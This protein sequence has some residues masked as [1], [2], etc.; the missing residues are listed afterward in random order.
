VIDQRNPLF[1][2]PCSG[3]IVG[4]ELYCLAATYLRL[5]EIGKDVKTDLLK[6]PLI[7]KYKLWGPG[8]RW[9]V[10]KGS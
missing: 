10:G 8:V 9:I 4:N 7:L 2:E 1:N 5:F 3:V 6:N